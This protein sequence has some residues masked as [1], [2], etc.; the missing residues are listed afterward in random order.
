MH[1][2]NGSDKCPVEIESGR[3]FFHSILDII[4][5]SVFRCCLD[6]ILH[7]TI[8]WWVREGLRS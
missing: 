6:P 4:Q 7:L 8:S 2:K 3:I 5:Y 1:G